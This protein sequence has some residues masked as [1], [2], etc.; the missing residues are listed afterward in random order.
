MRE[1]ERDRKGVGEENQER[2]LVQVR[3][4]RY[5]RQKYLVKFNPNGAD[6]LGNG[7]VWRYSYVLSS[8]S[9]PL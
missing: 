8:I 3:Q 5:F 4:V 6:T 7:S 1:R 9:R 2:M